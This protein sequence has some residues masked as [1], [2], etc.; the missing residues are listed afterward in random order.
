[1]FVDITTLSWEQ[2][3][4]SDSTFESPNFPEFT[5]PLF[6]SVDGTLEGY[7]RYFPHMPSLLENQYDTPLSA[8]SD[9]LVE[10]LPFAERD[11]N[12]RLLARDNNLNAGGFS[13]ANVQFFVAGDA[14]PFRVTSQ[15]EEEI[16]DVGTATTVSWDVANT[17]DPA[18]VNSALVDIYLSLIHI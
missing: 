4:A 3:D 18:G 8:G 5:G 16:W 17:V 1:M 13:Y 15:A 9:Y 12:M 2:N 6:C 7:K 11:L 14:G 10:K